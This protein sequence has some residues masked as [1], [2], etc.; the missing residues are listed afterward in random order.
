VIANQPQ[1]VSAGTA[2]LPDTNEMLSSKLY[3]TGI[4]SAFAILLSLVGVGSAMGQ[5][6]DQDMWMRANTQATRERAISEVRQAYGD[7]TIRRWSPALIEIQLKPRRPG[8]Y[9]AQRNSQEV[10]ADPTRTTS[11]TRSPELIPH[12]R[13][14]PIAAAD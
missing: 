13:D 12:S 11:A 7:G 14:V 4:R 3:I 2:A 6:S 8:P 10:S 1:A 5:S 9:V